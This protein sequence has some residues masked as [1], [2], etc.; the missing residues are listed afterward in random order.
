MATK[1]DTLMM[2][3]GYISLFF[4]YFD[5]LIHEINSELINIENTA[6]GNLISGKLQTNARIELYRDLLKTIPFQKKTIDQATS[7]INQFD[8]IRKTR[9]HFIHGIW[10]VEGDVEEFNE[11]DFHIGKL[12]NW[13]DA[14]KINLKELTKIKEDILALN[15]KQNQLNKDLVKEHKRIIKA[16]KKKR[17]QFNAVWKRATKSVELD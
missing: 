5:H 2:E 17:R 13:K 6:I 7:V 1:T 9:N 8:V 11:D 14:K 4:T 12:S 16:K 3:V 10:Y 15:Q